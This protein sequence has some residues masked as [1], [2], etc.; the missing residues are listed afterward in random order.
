MIKLKSSLNFRGFPEKNEI[1][2]FDG[3]EKSL[4]IEDFEAI[5]SLLN[6]YR[7][8][9]SKELTFE[10]EQWKA[11]YEINQTDFDELNDFL[12]VN[13]FLVKESIYS[14]D[15]ENIRNFN[16][17]SVYDHSSE[18]NTLMKKIENLHI[19]VI[20]TGTVGSSLILTL[21][22][23]GVKKFS[24][25]D[26]DIVE[27]KNIK[28]QF[29]FELSDVDKYKVDVIKEKLKTIDPF[30]K[31]N[32]Y[33]KRIENIT[34]FSDLELG[35]FDY[36]FGCFDN[37]TEVLHKGLA[38]EAQLSKAK[39]ILLGYFNDSTIANDITSDQGMD[40]LTTSYSNYSH[41]FISDNRGTIIQSMAGCM[42]VAKILM[43][44]L[45]GKKS[46]S[47]ISLRL[48]EMGNTKLFEEVS[49]NSND[50]FMGNLSHI[51]P[52]KEE[53][54]RRKLTYIQNCLSVSVDIP[55]HLELEVLAM[56]QVFDLLISTGS[57]EDYG[58]GG[59][60]DDF[61]Q[62]VE[63]LDQSEEDSTVYIS[64]Q[65]QEQYLDL[66]RNIQVPGH[67]FTNIFEA[68][69]SINSIES[70]EDRMKLQKDCHFSI[71]EE[72]ER[73]ISFFKQVKNK[74]ATIPLEHY[75]QE[76]LGIGEEKVNAVDKV[77]HHHL[78]EL[79][80][81]I[82]RTLF[83]SEDDDLVN[84]DYLYKSLE[85]KEVFGEI[86][87]AGA[88]LI[89]SLN[90]KYKNPFITEHIKMM[91]SGNHIK[92]V[93]ASKN[94]GIN[95]NYYFP[96]LKLNKMILSY[97]GSLES[98]FILCH[99]LGHSYYNK[100]YNSSFYNDSR[101]LLNETLAYL[102]ELFCVTSIMED[103]SLDEPTKEK[104]HHQYLFRLNKIVL[105]QYSIYQLESELVS[106]LSEH[107]D[108]TLKDY[109]AIQKDLDT[110]STPDSVQFTNQE[111]THMNAL[112]NTPFI[113]GFKDH[114]TS[115]LAYLLA[116]SLLT[117]YKGKENMLDLSIKSAL[118][119]NEISVEQFITKVLEHEENFEEVISHGIDALK[120]FIN[121]PQYVCN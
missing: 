78:E 64:E 11:R 112:L 29:L 4:E 32:A 115:P 7:L 93:D 73:L 27:K 26:H 43:D 36:I 105:S 100:M 113:F 56:Y 22:K 74:F 97:A 41:Y 24:I 57:I 82:G 1:R 55:N 92:I 49:S 18:A 10:L 31:V 9:D 44:D 72:G 104:I 87:K 20:G 53:E 5:W 47:H 95:R 38:K 62:L 106:Y 94:H 116:F 37:S 102:F 13:G 70:Y 88:M 45:L 67:A 107:G 19:V 81:L 68:L 39:Y 108:L 71:I 101:T 25:I 121:Q 58:L 54:I 51:M 120:N 50:L 17:F 65:L 110:T 79:V 80:P 75:Y 89:G 63:F 35:S 48:S 12:L 83:P 117:K 3:E 86:E 2:Y 90:R 111:Y 61:L 99:E 69:N 21:S 66:V 118:E 28:A 103:T 6:I 91:F 14:D 16:Y 60:Y 96:H 34:E 42:L 23:L 59:V 119:E 98:F 84:I 33:N 77:L 85:Y 109:L 76:T 40:I 8:E 15:P 46:S 52:L 30:C 114:I